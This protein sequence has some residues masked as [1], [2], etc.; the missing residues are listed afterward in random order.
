MYVYLYWPVQFHDLALSHCT[1][2]SMTAD[3]YHSGKCKYYC[4][5]EGIDLPRP[6]NKDL[7]IIPFQKVDA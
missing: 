7:W 2:V 3:G 5:N 4:Q 6:L 1:T